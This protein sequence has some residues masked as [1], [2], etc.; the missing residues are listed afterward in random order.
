MNRMLFILFL[1]LIISACGNNHSI[2]LNTPDYHNFIIAIDD[3]DI[4]YIKTQV[5]KYNINYSLLGL[6]PIHWV[7]SREAFQI[8]IDNNAEVN[9][10]KKYS[11]IDCGPLYSA[12][13][14]DR[15]EIVQLLLKC[16]A[17]I[18]A[19]NKENGETALH[20]AVK[21]GREKTVKLLVMN[22][23]DVNILDKN[24]KTA[25]DYAVMSDRSDIIRILSKK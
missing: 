25:L 7:N 5:K 23:I 10:D 17:N 2:V 20:N 1:M 4:D 15:F 3:N 18:N 21:Q 11:D 9:P 12:A 16:G 13:G 14:N 22:G 19:I 8:L 6:M 24:G